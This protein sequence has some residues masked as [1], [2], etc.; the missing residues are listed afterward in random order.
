MP[1][2]S[3]IRAGR[4][5]LPFCHFQLIGQKPSPLPYPVQLSTLGDHLRKR[6]LD[7][8]LLQREVAEELGVT[9]ATIWNWEANHGS[10]QLRFIPSVISFL[11]YDPY[12]TQAGSLG[13]RIVAYR[14]AAGLSQKELARRLGIDPSTLGNWERGEKQPPSKLIP[15]MEVYLAAHLAAA[16]DSD[17]AEV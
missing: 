9:A 2:R 14:R 3:I 13:E 8:G 11:G 10:P 17:S 15:R 1:P 4:G 5:S 7:L 6:R 12:S 16:A